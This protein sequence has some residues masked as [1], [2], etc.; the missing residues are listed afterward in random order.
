M[1]TQR[2]PN[3]DLEM[4]G[5]PMGATLTLHDSPTQTCIVVQ[6]NGPPRVA[7]AGIVQS[8]SAAAQSALQLDYQ[9][10]GALHWEYNGELLQARRERY[11]EYYRRAFDSGRSG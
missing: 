5:V 7:R 9:P 2:E 11:E 3:I 1:S 10:N 4:I 8:L 6:L